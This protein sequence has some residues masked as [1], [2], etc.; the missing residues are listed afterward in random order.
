[1][2]GLNLGE[3]RL[4]F[5]LTCDYSL[6]KRWF[7]LEIHMVLVYDSQN[8]IGEPIDLVTHG[9]KLHTVHVEPFILEYLCVFHDCHRGLREIQGTV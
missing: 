5:P 1:M 7:K 3:Q 9:L 4:G 6:K 8:M 2:T